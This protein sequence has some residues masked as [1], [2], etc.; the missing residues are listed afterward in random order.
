[1]LT[2]CGSN[3]VEDLRE[4]FCVCVCVFVRMYACRERVII[5]KGLYKLYIESLKRKSTCDFK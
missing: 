4:M 3:A 1:M 2:L 5:E